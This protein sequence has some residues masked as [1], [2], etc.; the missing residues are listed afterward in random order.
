MGELAF[1]YLSPDNSPKIEHKT[2][3]VLESNFAMAERKKDAAS[4]HPNLVSVTPIEF[5]YLIVGCGYTR[6]LVKHY[7]DLGA[8]FTLK[9]KDHT[10]TQVNS[11]WLKAQKDCELAREHMYAS[12]PEYVDDPPIPLY[13]RDWDERYV[14]S[15]DPTN[16]DFDQKS[17]AEEAQTVLDCDKCDRATIAFP[18][19]SLFDAFE[20][21]GNLTQLAHCACFG[22]TP[23]DMVLVTHKNGKRA[24]IMKFDTE[25]G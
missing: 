16:P 5:N 20:I 8:W 21:V 19:S 18:C 12:E 13:I 6:R 1:Q 3:I 17:L 2:R 15:K 4:D 25:S 14:L 9:N 22:T 7:L 10:T 23:Y 24:L 11:E